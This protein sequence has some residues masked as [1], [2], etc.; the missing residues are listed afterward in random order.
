MQL[1]CQTGTAII[2]T[3]DAAVHILL[4]CLSDAI[5]FSSGGPYRP[6]LPATSPKPMRLA[7]HYDCGHKWEHPRLQRRA[8]WQAGCSYEGDPEG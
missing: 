2:Q 4:C 8:V 7:V 3:F 5:S 6:L 1:K